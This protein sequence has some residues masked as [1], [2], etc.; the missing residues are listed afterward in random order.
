M[1]IV[2][3]SNPKTNITWR[4]IKTDAPN[5]VINYEHT[6]K[7][8]NIQ[9]GKAGSYNCTASNNIGRSQAAT[10]VVDVQ[11]MYYHVDLNLKVLYQKR[12]CTPSLILLN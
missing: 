8:H 12:L 2:T 1:C 6:Y 7:I 4:W 9:R 10:V 11:C 5:T 3:D